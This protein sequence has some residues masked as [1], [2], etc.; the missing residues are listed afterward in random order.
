MMHVEDSIL[1]STSSIHDASTETRRRRIL[2]VSKEISRA[3]CQ[4]IGECKWPSGGDT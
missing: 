1:S 3:E 2:Q 4:Y